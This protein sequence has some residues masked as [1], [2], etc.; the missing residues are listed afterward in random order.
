MNDNTNNEITKEK[1]LLD[2]FSDTLERDA[3]VN[4]K[5]LETLE[6]IV[7]RQNIK[8]GIFFGLFVF[9]ILIIYLF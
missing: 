7:K 9:L 2:V 3:N 1:D 4:I 5:M 6:H 8:D